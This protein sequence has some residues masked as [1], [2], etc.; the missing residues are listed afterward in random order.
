MRAMTPAL[1]AAID[2]EVTTLALCWRLVRADGVGLGF[3][4]H[5]RPLLID[6]LWHR[7]APGLRPSAI[8]SLEGAG[9]EAMEVTGA[10]SAAAVSE[11][12]LL[13]GR[14]DGAAAASFLVN[15]SDPAGGAL[16]LATGRIGAVSARDGAFTAALVTPLDTLS[17][18][19]IERYSPEC[20]ARLGDARCR[21]D[22]SGRTRMA[23]VAFVA[24]AFTFEVDVLLAAEAHRY[25]RLRV[26][27][28]D[29]GGE[30]RPIA[31]TEGARVRS[32]GGLAGL[33]TG[34]YVELR[35]GCDKRFE[36][37]RDRFGNGANFRGE[38][39]VP[40]GDAMAR[41]GSLL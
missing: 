31:T 8:E 22:L 27:S 41:Y 4:T 29:A 23:R 28:G 37:C 10:L 12:E 39:H 15:W 40:G 20:R 14:Y 21:V 5:D 36:T 16:E 38:P 6:G 2:G 34:D 13:A 24:D 25:G 18:E 33:A 19:P 9:G 32:D 7:P 35:E 11:A 3:T 30:E 1:A 26:V 17:A